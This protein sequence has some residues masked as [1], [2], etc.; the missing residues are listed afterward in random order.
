MMVKKI[1]KYTCAADEFMKKN[2]VFCAALNHSLLAIGSVQ[3]GVCLL[4]L[5]KK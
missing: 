1:E 3:D 2:R 5:E 4:N